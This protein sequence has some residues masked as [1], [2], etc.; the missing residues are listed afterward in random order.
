MKYIIGVDGGGTKTLGIL[1]DTD[2]NVV[3]KVLSGVG[4]FSVDPEQT[5]ENLF[6]V[7][8][9]L[10][11][12]VDIADLEMIQIGI[13]GYT[14]YPHKIEL[15][16][17][18]QGMYT[19]RTEIVTDAE[20][21]LYSVKKDS[22]LDVIMALG[23]TGSVVMVEHQGK[24]RFIGGYGHL[25][26]DEG[27][28]YHLA[29]TALKNII[30]QYEKSLPGTKLSNDI[31]AKIEAK[32]YSEI[33]NFVYNHP[34]SEIARLS[35]FIATHALEG[36]IEAIELFK[37]E[38]R[39]LADQAIKAYNTLPGKPEVMIGLKGGFL[40]NAPYVKE[41]FVSELRKAEIRY[42]M[43]DSLLDPVYGAYYMAKKH[44]NER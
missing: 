15:L 35:E 22:D 25:L 8:E 24:I 1:F 39:L 28:G 10:T 23:G 12:G 33:K 27:S 17:R 16:D 29:I 32:N 40:L 21:A 31:L 38:G 41:T 9:T 44:L 11:S 6:E 37:Q 18:I 42:K 26:G 14:N 2:G 30:D 5:V 7:L 34:K 20:I 4:N 13:A 36:D 19:T 3:R 43:D